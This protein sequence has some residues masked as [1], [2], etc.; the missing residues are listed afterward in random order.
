VVGE[1]LGRGGQLEGRDPLRVNSDP[2]MGGGMGQLNT[3][4]SPGQEHVRS[5]HENRCRSD[6][7]TITIIESDITTRTGIESG[8]TTRSS[9]L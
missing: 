7:S 5:H 3:M 1:G 2:E 6:I 8:L 9:I 4:L